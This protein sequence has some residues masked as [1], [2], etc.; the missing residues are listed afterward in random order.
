M[1]E[2]LVVNFFA[3]SSAGKSTNSARLYSMLKDLGINTELVREYAKDIVWE[4]RHKIFECQMKISAEQLFRQLRLKDKVDVCVTDSPILLG[5]IY[6]HEQDVN[7][8]QYLLTQFNKFNNLN[9]YLE[10]V[11]PFS[12]IGRNEKT[13]EEAKVFDNKV[14]NLLNDNN[15]PY[16]RV[17]GNEEGCFEI[18]EKIKEILNGI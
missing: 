6:D 5:A 10:R 1:K 8:K 9:I 7:L 2:A 14:L 11:K 13:I 18:V 16:G 15:I 12:P 17:K 4:E 3:G